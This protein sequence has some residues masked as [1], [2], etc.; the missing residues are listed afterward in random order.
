MDEE[1]TDKTPMKNSVDEELKALL[2]DIKVNIKIIG[3][4]GGGCNTIARIQEEGIH[5]AE[6]YAA[7]TDAQHLL[8]LRL[9][10]RILLGKKTTKGLGAGANP[11]VGEEAAKEEEDELRKV[12]EHSQIVFLTCGLGG[13][14][15]TGSI[16]YVSKLAQES[17]ALTI[18]FTTLPFR[19]EGK[20]RMDNALTGLSM[21]RHYADTVVT[22]PNDKLL[23]IVPRLPL[24]K[25]FKVADEVL[26]NSIKSITETITKPGLVNL[27]L[28]DVKTVMKKGG[29]AVIGLGESNSP[30][31]R[32]AM[33]AAQEAVNSPLLDADLHTATGVLVNVTGPTNMS[34][35]EAETVMEFVQEKVSTN[36]R[37]IWGAS[38]DPRLDA[39]HYM[40]VI[41]VAT[42][43]TPKMM[44]GKTKK[45]PVDRVR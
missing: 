12:F 7:N 20:S 13:G 14:T 1:I 44:I 11:Q 2:E 32:R 8:T 4:G 39:T 5:G 27:D 42:G 6:L 36:S 18:G 34:I 38:I 40:K 25:A 45:L 28:N 35:K 29:S 19:G 43:V 41:L 23:D 22:I 26:M 9:P 3:L 37:I 10:K 24:N 21:L 33:D 31:D 15:G 16:P 17:G 30:G